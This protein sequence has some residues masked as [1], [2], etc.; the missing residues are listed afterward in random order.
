MM[1]AGR[2]ILPLDLVGARLMNV[3][4]WESPL[5]RFVMMNWG[6]PE[7]QV[8]DWD[9][10]P[11]EIHNRGHRPGDLH[12][13]EWGAAAG[14]LNLDTNE[15]P[16]FYGRRVSRDQRKFTGKWTSKRLHNSPRR[17]DGSAAQLRMTRNRSARA[18]SSFQRCRKGGSVAPCGSRPIS[19]KVNVR[20]VRS[21]A[22]E[23]S[24]TGI[25]VPV[26]QK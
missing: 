19:R 14:I 2:D 9:S 23:V 24:I 6:Q 18:P 8:E 4:A 7:I 16:P 25:H 12:H 15:F 11:E 5:P 22:V 26:L 10:V 3:D 1:L 21:S 17:P 20:S 13:R